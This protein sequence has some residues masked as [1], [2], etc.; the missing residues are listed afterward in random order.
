MIASNAEADT[1][2]SGVDFALGMD[3]ALGCE[4]TPDV[5][6]ALVCSPLGWFV[7]DD[8]ARSVR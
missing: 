6:C 8:D 1:A 2:S 3:F 7:L 5:D 4:F